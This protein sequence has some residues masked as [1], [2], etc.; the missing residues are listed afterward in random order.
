MPIIHMS[1]QFPKISIV[2]P[3]FNQGNFIEESI[4]SVIG[5]KYPNLEYIIMD[6]GSTDNS[7]EVIKKYEQHITY[8]TSQKDDGMYDALNRGF[9]K[10]TGEIMGWL[11]SDD[12]LLN[13]SLFTLADIFQN[14]ADVEWLQGYPCMADESGRIVFQR[15]QRSSR[16]SFYRKEYHDG[17]F[18]QQESTYWRRSLWEKSGAS[19]SSDYKYAGDFELWM[20]FYKYAEQFI[21]PALIGAFRLR[22]GQQSEK[23]YPSY[24]QECDQVIDLHI[25]ELPNEDKVILKK[26]N[27]E[28]KYTWISALVRRFGF[29]NYTNEKQKMVAYDNEKGKFVKSR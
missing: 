28:R 7:M 14:N 18:I 25:K 26:L 1:D 15:P 6:G 16:F 29:L 10:A 24:L 20:R 8:F 23:Y 17:I 27:L 4:L 22:K 3:T 13:K 21:T 19:I 11:N 2:T 5:Q 12:L 9:K